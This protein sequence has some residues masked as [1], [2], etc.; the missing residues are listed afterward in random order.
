MDVEEAFS[1]AVEALGVEVE[2]GSDAAAAA[3]AAPEAAAYQT[4]AF[5]DYDD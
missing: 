5:C 3:T 1:A 2:T 4:L